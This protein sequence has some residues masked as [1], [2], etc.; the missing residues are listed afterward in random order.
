M[1]QDLFLA[2]TDT[3]QIT[4]EWALSEL[5]KNPSL[6]KKAQAEID[7]AIGRERLLEET[8]V[9]RLPYLQA[10]VKETLRIH[11][12]VPLLQHRAENT[13]EI[14]GFVIPKGTSVIIN[15]WAI[16]RDP[17]AWKEPCEFR[18]ERFLQQNVDFRG[19]DFEFI[20]FGAGRR[21][22]VGMPLA[23]VII[24]SVL[25]A[26]IQSFDWHGEEDLDMDYKF[27]VTMHRATPLLATPT[28][29]LSSTVYG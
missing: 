7:E 25:G 10:V 14:G 5:I 3:T 21:I 24:H 6:M 8:D 15:N 19:R 23:N 22:C 28:P 11:P 26:L 4:V 12:A 29:R 27:A 18:P 20:P 13:T 2:G 17:S 9:E 1:M 16:A